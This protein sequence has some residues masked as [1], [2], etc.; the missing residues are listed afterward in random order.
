MTSW[1]QRI[2]RR[3]EPDVA[4]EEREKVERSDPVEE[5]IAANERR[6]TELDREIEAKQELARGLEDMRMTVEA[7]KLEK[8]LGS[9][10]EQ[11]KL[12]TE[13]TRRLRKRQEEKARAEL[14]LERE[15]ES[16]LYR[17]RS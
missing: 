15:R 6:S 9:L 7:P 8:R 2:V 10:Q 17:G 5:Q 16:L 13:E 1:W 14:A 4:P 12:L 3:F 11:I